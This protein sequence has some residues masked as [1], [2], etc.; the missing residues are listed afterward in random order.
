MSHVADIILITMIEDGA[1]TEDGHP[2]ADKLNDYLKENH[3]GANLVM[4]D[5]YA[6]G[7]KHMQCD[8]FMAAI[9]YLNIKDFVKS[10]Q[11]IDWEY[12]EGSQLL[13]KDEHDDKFT[14]YNKE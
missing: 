6:G 4:V 9:N 10:F 11:G 3:N 8:V 2:N 13:I 5:G 1:D 12:P 14:V 7:N